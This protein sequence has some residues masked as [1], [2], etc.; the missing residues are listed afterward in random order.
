MAQLVRGR[1]ARCQR[2]L[3]ENA[4]MADPHSPWCNV[5]QEDSVAYVFFEVNYLMMQ[6][7]LADMFQV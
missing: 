7:S 2:R 1:L 4:A 6:D 5:L 3:H